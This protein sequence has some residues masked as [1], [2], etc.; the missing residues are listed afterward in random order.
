MVSDA[1]VTVRR[2]LSFTANLQDDESNKYLNMESMSLLEYVKEYKYFCVPPVV[3]IVVLCFVTACLCV[4][5]RRRAEEQM[6]CYQ[7]LPPGFSPLLRVDDRP[8]VHGSLSQQSTSP[9]PS[10]RKEGIW[11]SQ[12]PVTVAAMTAKSSQESC[13]LFKDLKYKWCVNLM[14]DIFIPRCEEAVIYLILP[15][16][17][18][19]LPKTVPPQRNFRHR[20]FMARYK[21]QRNV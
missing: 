10:L 12:G 17:Q 8:H 18:C 13:D 15:L 9:S 5:D 11:P 3:G 6:F 20:W 1:L 21:D 2:V 7:S 4:R 16:D 14:L 19:W